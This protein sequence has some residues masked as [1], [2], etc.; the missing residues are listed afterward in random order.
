VHRL[1]LQTVDST[2]AE[3]ARRAD[4]MPAP[5]WV[6]AR[7]QTGG[8]GRRG[9][10]WVSPPGNFYATCLMRPAGA[11]DVVALR[12]FAA[13]LALHDACSAL[14]G[15]PEA[16]AL[17]WP[18]DVLLNGGKLAGILLEA[19][20]SG[21]TVDHLAIGIGVNLASAPPAGS[22]EPGALRPVSLRGET[23]LT[24]PPEAF[25]DHLAPAL[26]RW[27]ATLVTQGFAPL[28][29][30]WLA[31]A[32][33]LGQALRARTGQADHHGIFETVDAS[34]ALVLRTGTG[35]LAIAAAEV[36]F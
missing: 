15:R 30:A 9:R 11:A 8:R 33:R 25:L 10:P 12:S 24:V 19:Q 7:A 32:A 1:I 21:G 22:V 2:N 5:F 13:A 35:P 14:T 20:G 26:A 34:G 29:M 18:N 28:R 3:A 6:M 4:T 23:G 31:R 16:L 36:F 17:K 27:E